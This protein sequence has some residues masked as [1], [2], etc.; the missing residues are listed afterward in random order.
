MDI[1][2]SVNELLC[3]CIEHWSPYI[4]KEVTKE[5]L[6]E[7]FNMVCGFLF[8]PEC[9]DTDIIRL[10]ETI[11]YFLKLS[12]TLLNYLDEEQMIALITFAFEAHYTEDLDLCNLIEEFIIK[13]HKTRPPISIGSRKC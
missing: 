4:E 5:R 13:S 8:A 9:S 11:G 6:R 2:N 7:W 3:Y 12:D 1:I 10:I